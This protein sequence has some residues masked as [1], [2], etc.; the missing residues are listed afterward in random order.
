MISRSARL[1]APGAGRLYRTAPAKVEDP[2]SPCHA[3][4]MWAPG[5][6]GFLEWTRTGRLDDAYAGEAENAYRSVALI[7]LKP[8]R[9][10]SCCAVTL[11]VSVDTLKELDAT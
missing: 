7:L 5:G 1:L 11:S 2:A 6:P 9:W 10:F 3:G 4:K 8:A